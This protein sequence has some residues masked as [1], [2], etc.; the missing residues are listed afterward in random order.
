MMLLMRFL[1][2]SPPGFAGPVDVVMVALRE[3]DGAM[4]ATTVVLVVVDELVV[5]LKRVLVGRA[6]V[7]VVI[8]RAVVATVVSGSVSAGCDV[9]ASVGAGATVVDTTTLLGG[10]VDVPTRVVDEPPGTVVVG[11]TTAVVVVCASTRC[12]SITTHTNAVAT[13]IAAHLWLSPT[14]R[15]RTYL[16]Q[17]NYRPHR[18][19]DRS[20]AHPQP[21]RT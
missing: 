13:T 1:V 16:P 11:V 7:V 21:S 14:N 19:G 6:A 17:P 2:A 3:V 18:F 4:A 15:S 8:R 10:N 9:G 5:V 12:G 20:R